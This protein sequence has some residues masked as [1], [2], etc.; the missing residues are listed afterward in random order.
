MA[1]LSSAF[2]GRTKRSNF[3]QE[4]ALVWNLLSSSIVVDLLCLVYNKYICKSCFFCITWTTLSVST[5]G[6]TS[7]RSWDSLFY[8][9]LIES[10]SKG[11][12][13]LCVSN[14]HWFCALRYCSRKSLALCANRELSLWQPLRLTYIA[15]AKVFEPIFGQFLTRVSIDAPATQKEAFSSVP[16]KKVRTQCILVFLA[17]EVFMLKQTRTDGAVHP[18]ASHERCDWSP[19][20][21]NSQLGMPQVI[22]FLLPYWK[23]V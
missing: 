3:L 22:L 6:M 9:Y 16:N 12:C 11:T 5:C 2:Q 10:F 21:H 1:W 17:R 20:R 4:T 13:L 23:T 19:F 8:K 14:F 15:E 7:Y 18:Q